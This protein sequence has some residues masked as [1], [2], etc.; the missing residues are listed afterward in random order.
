M[1]YYNLAKNNS[2]NPHFPKFRG[3]VMKVTDGIFAIRIERLLPMKNRKLADSIYL[4]LSDIG[5]DVY[6]SIIDQK[7]PD[8]IPCLDAIKTLIKLTRCRND[9]HHENIKLRGDIPVIIDP[10]VE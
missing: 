5:D 9:A 7:Y 10:M 1:E 3:N 4:Y 8:L 6:M 2:T